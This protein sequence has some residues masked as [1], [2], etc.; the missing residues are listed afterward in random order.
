MELKEI[1]KKEFERFGFYQTEIEGNVSWIFEGKNHNLIVMINRK[2]NSL[3]LSQQYSEDGENWEFTPF[4]V[5]A[6]LFEVIELARV[7][8][9]I[10]IGTR[11]YNEDWKESNIIEGTEGNKHGK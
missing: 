7:A 3:A 8:Y 5:M 10:S 11:S 9:G 1:V 6:P 2:T 4:R